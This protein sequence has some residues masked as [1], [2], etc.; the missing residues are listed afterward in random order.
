V[1][2]DI[3]LTLT[4]AGDIGIN[5]SKLFIADVFMSTVFTMSLVEG[6]LFPVIAIP[7]ALLLWYVVEL[8]LLLKK[9]SLKS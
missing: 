3:V 5:R 2:V 8:S 1:T 6:A 4:G 9:D 7:V